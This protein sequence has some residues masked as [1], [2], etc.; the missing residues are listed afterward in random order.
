MQE[1]VITRFE[2]TSNYIEA[3]LKSDVSI[4]TLTQ[5]SLMSQSVLYELF[6][7]IFKISIK[8]DINKRR[9]TLAGKMKVTN[10]AFEAMYQSPES[11]S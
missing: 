9:L 8:D 4:E 7:R 3:N 11:F 1:D 10:S 2:N 5:I 6:T